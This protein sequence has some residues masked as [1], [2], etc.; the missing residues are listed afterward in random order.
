MGI[1]LLFGLVFGANSQWVADV[2]GFVAG[3]ALSFGVSPGG[4]HKIR[5]WLQA[6]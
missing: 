4:W 3:F 2:T 5:G 1:Q 6:R